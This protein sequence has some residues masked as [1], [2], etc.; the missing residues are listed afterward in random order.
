MDHKLHHD[1]RMADGTWA[2]SIFPQWGFKGPLALCDPVFTQPKFRSIT[3]ND[4]FGQKK[5]IFQIT[6]S[7]WLRG[8]RTQTQAKQFSFWILCTLRTDRG[9]LKWKWLIKES[10]ISKHMEVVWITVEGSTSDTLKGPSKTREISK[11]TIPEQT[12][13]EP[14][15]H[16]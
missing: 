3:L 12:W 1:F 2:R 8:L 7:Y 16:K 11:T 10:V 13:T 6:I 9:T 14:S 4:A 5:P 15:R